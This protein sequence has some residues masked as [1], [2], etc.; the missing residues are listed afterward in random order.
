M[1]IAEKVCR[2]TPPIPREVCLRAINVD[3]LRQFNDRQS[4]IAQAHAKPL[5]GAAGDAFLSKDLNV[6]GRKIQRIF[7]QHIRALQAV[8]S[9]L[10]LMGQ[11]KNAEFSEAQQ[12]ELCFII[13]TPPRELGKLLDEAGPSGLKDAADKTVNGQWDAAEIDSCVMLAISQFAKHIQTKVRI[14]GEAA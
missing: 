6:N 11:Q 2:N 14:A 4:K 3:A 12:A 5:P 8:E 1:D 7:P 9:P 10:L 13:T